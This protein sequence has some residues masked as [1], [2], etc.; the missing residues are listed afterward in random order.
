MARIFPEHAASVACAV[1]LLSPRE[2]AALERLLAKW[3]KTVQAR[4]G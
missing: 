3:G 1:A 4:E 2:R